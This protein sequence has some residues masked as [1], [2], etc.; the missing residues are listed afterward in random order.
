MRKALVAVWD[1][2]SKFV[3]QIAYFVYNLVKGALVTIWRA[4][5]YAFYLIVKKVFVQVDHTYFW[6]F[7]FLLKSLRTLGLLGELIFTIFGLLWLLWPLYLAYKLQQW[8]ERYEWWL[9]AIILTL[10]LI[11]RGRKVIINAK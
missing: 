8:H 2:V 5:V 9:G 4:T 7:E 11:I 1:S 3:N 6:V 10:I